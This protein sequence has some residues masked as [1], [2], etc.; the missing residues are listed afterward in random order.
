MVWKRTGLHTADRASSLH[1][2]SMYL[3]IL[4]GNHIHSEASALGRLVLMEAKGQSW[5]PPSP[6]AAMFRCPPARSVPSA[7]LMVPALDRLKSPGAVGDL[8]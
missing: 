4:N 5:S 3:L 7:A 1:G 2:M 8:D 6:P